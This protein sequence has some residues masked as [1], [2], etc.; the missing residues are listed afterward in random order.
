M[1]Q[2]VS[3]QDQEEKESFKLIDASS[4]LLGVLAA[5]ITTA[6]V[7][8]DVSALFA[9][10]VGVGI[11]H[12]FRYGLNIVANRLAAREKA[13]VG[14]VYG[15]ATHKI[16]ERLDN[17]ETPRTDG[18]FEPD[19]TGCSAADESAEAVF[20]TAQKEYEERKLP[21]IAN[22]LDF[23]AFTPGIHRAMANQLV[24]L[25]SSLSYRQFCLLALAN[26]PT[27]MNMYSETYYGSTGQEAASLVALLKELFELYQQHLIEI[28]G[29]LGTISRAPTDP[30]SMPLQNLL[31]DRVGDL[32]YQGM[33]LS[34]LP[35]SEYADIVSTLTRRR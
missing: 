29:T 20:L 27:R 32:L 34:D 28:E 18:F 5:G 13:R 2:S 21:Y 16:Q 12:A 23:L 22:L 26:E 10:S 9:G 30:R 14:V 33:R 7:Y 25:A 11:A 24:R 4:D 19:V 17:G 1:R 6:N 15:L 35:P 3:E 8:H 31:L